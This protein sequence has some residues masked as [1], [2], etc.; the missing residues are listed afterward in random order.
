MN[1]SGNKRAEQYTMSWVFGLFYSFAKTRYIILHWIKY[2]NSKKCPEMIFD[3]VN[4]SHL[5]LVSKLIN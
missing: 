5:F 1:A 2:R 4:V 3:V